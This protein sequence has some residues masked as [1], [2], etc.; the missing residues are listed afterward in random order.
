LQQQCVGEILRENVLANDPY[1]MFAKTL[2]LSPDWQD[3]EF[4]ECSLSEF[5]LFSVRRG[6]NLLVGRLQQCG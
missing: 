1:G 3:Q 2:C 5:S 6:L 4:H